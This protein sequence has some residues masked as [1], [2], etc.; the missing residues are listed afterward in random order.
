MI[1]CFMTDGLHEVQIKMFT[2]RAGAA[3]STLLVCRCHIF[4]IDY[5]WGIGPTIPLRT[6]GALGYWRF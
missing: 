6:M 4:V 3:Q 1:I 2:S 5:R